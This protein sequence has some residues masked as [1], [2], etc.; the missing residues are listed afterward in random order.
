[1]LTTERHLLVREGTS[2]SSLTQ[3]GGREP[4]PGRLALVQAFLNT[5]YDPTPGCHGDEVLSSPAALADWLAE[6]GLL[7]PRARLRSG[8]LDRALALREALRDLLRVGD[9]HAPAR[10]RANRLARV[11]HLARGAAVEINL[12]PDGPRFTSPDETSMAGAV[13]AL[14]AIV[15]ASMLDGTWLRM[16]LCPGRHCGWAFYDHSRNQ[17][18]RWCSMSVCGGREKARAHYQRRRGERN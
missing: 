18:G 16:K 10:E 1:M 8:D 2:S 17:A 7:A 3:P 4:A 14:M 6:R 11:N 9:A 15:A 12:E 13:G 5:F